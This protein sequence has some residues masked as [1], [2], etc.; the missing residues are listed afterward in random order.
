[1]WTLIITWVMESRW[2][3][4]VQVL[5]RFRPAKSDGR[6]T[7]TNKQTVVCLFEYFVK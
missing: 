5:I 4:T 1:M 3:A 6:G 7:I 2:L